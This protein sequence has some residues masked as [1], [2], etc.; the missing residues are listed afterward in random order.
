MFKNDVS[1]WSNLESYN[2]AK[3]IVDSL[4]V[5]N[6]VAERTLKL[7]TDV[8]G[9]LTNNEDEKQRAIQ[10]IEDNR[11]RV[12]TTQKFVLSNCKRL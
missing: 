9:S 12:P 2:T 8:N 5:V 1:E 3:K 7:M 4:K 10:V 11:K 6:D